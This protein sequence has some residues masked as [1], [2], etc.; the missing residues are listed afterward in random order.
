MTLPVFGSLD[1]D[2]APHAKVNKP[3]LDSLQ[4]SNYK[5]PLDTVATWLKHLTL[6]PAQYELT[7]KTLWDLKRSAVD[8]LSLQCIIWQDRI[9]DLRIFVC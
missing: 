3:V 4:E 1:S 5:H 7:L 9:F 2:T 6:S 8:S